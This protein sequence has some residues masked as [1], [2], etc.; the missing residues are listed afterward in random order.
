MSRLNDLT[1]KRFGRLTVEG[2]GK[3]YIKP[4][5]KH[6]VTF[7]CKCDCGSI[8]EIR[9]SN[10]KNGTTKS[11]GCL[12]TELVSKRFLKHGQRNTRLYRIWCAMKA[13]CLNPHVK[14]YKNYGGRGI[15]ICPEWIDSFQNFY[16]WAMS[17]GYLDNLSIDRIDVNG[18][19]E[20]SNC[21]WASSFT[22]TRNRRSNVT[23]EYQGVKKVL[24]DWA[25]ISE[26]DPETISNRL[27]AGWKVEEAL[28]IAPEL[29]NNQTLRR[30]TD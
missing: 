26:I 10:L 30:E 17:H 22:Q 16:N 20:P 9:S 11:C 8:K 23:I 28:T 2:R 1:G 19:Y 24:S 21:R 27:S 3:D 29:G 13:R 7:I 6:E 15:K 14:A 4:S 12:M 5:G 18:N 25:K